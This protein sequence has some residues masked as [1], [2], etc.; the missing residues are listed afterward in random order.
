MYVSNLPLNKVV[1]NPIFKKTWRLLGYTVTRDKVI[2]LMNTEF[3][4]LVEQICVTLSNRP[5]SDL[6]VLVF[7]KWTA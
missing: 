7:D 1:I 6:P 4:A 5:T 2:T 3:N